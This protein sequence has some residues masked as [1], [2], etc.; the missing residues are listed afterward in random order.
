[1]SKKALNAQRKTLTDIQKAWRTTGQ[2]LF[3]NGKRSDSLELKHKG[4]IQ[5]ISTVLYIQ[6]QRPHQHQSL[7]QLTP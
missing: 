4:M 2:D 3:Q 6:V 5:D 1:M 7:N